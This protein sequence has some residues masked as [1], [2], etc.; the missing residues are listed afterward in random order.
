MLGGFHVILHFFMGI[1][2]G[3]LICTG[4]RGMD[5]IEVFRQPKRGLAIARAA[6]PGQ[7]MP[8]SN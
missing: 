8:R 7:G 1:G 2:K 5:S 6:V 4:V 3:Y